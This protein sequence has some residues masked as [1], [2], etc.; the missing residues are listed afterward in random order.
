MFALVGNSNMARS[1]VALVSTSTTLASFGP[2][3]SPVM[4]LSTA[5]SLRHKMY[6]SPSSWPAYPTP[7]S[8]KLLQVIVAHRHGD[9]AP[10]S[11]SAGENLIP[12][13]TTWAERLPTAATTELWDAAVP[14]DGPS[15]A[16]DAGEEPFGVLTIRGAQQCEELGDSI[17]RSLLAHSPHL[18]P[19][20][21]S[22][23]RLRATNIRRTQQS[24]QNAVF[25]LLGT[26]GSGGGGSGELV[27][28][29]AS[30]LLAGLRIHVNEFDA[31]EVRIIPR[32]YSLSW[33]TLLLQ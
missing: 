28:P 10:I 2:C 9:R 23:L 12:D 16:V 3:W 14:V 25:G 24:V 33:R 30:P 20:E 8:K 26:R 22:H 27:E 29:E 5:E 17:R 32:P 31:S 11:A 1:A 21:A 4:T 7:G 18:L 13:P 15:E 19:T 6:S